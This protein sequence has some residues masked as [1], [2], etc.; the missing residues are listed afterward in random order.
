MQL[1]ALAGAW[2]SAIELEISA[3]LC[4]NWFGKDFTILFYRGF[5]L[6][7]NTA[8]KWTDL[9]QVFDPTINLI[10]FN[11]ELTPSLTHNN[12]Q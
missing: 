8:A 6:Y 1:A 3:G 5:R 4:D 11:T 12:S 9:A 10:C 7:L 2:P